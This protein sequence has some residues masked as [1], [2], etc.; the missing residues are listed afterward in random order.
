MSINL[1]GKERSITVLHI[2]GMAMIL[3]CHIFQDAGIS[4]LGEL[5][6][7]GVPLFLF[8]AGY[9]SGKKKITNSLEWVGRRLLRLLVPFY[10]LLVTLFIIYEIF[11]VAEVSSFQWIFCSLNLQGLNYTYWKFGLYSSIPGTGPFW[12]LTTMMFAYFLTPL[13]NKFRDID[14]TAWK[15]IIL[16]VSL[17]CVQILAMFFGVQ[18]NYLLVYVMGYFTGVKGVRQDGKYYFIINIM[19]VVVTAVRFV[20]R[21][22]IDGSDFYDRFYALISSTA[23]ALWIFYTVFYLE[24]KFRC[25]N[26]FYGFP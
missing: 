1:K 18:L 20:L 16:V 9:L 5:L 21:V 12:F 26:H 6:I 10:I 15:K 25:K 17:I 24:K 2:L 7:A 11:N 13:L 22:V 14:L 4:F 19:T 8:V 3:F 23:I